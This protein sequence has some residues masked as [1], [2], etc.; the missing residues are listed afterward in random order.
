MV[1][2]RRSRRA[3][4]DLRWGGSAPWSPARVTRCRGAAAVGPADGLTRASGAAATA[5]H[6]ASC[7]H[8]RCVL[9]PRLR[10]EST[11]RGETWIEQLLFDLSVDL[12]RDGDR[13][14]KLT[15]P[16]VVGRPNELFDQRADPGVVPPENVGGLHDLNIR[17]YAYTSGRPP[18]R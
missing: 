16:L 6:S 5:D 18:D 15:T 7:R 3:A 10:D 8:A 2:S 17:S 11:Q 14:H 4:E 13:G 1:G 12:E 9:T